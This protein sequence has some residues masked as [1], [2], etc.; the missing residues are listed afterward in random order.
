VE[1]PIQG[2]E[3]NREFLLYG[4]FWKMLRRDSRPRLSS[5][6]KLRRRLRGRWA[7]A[8]KTTDRLVPL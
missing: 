2:A 5:G 8:E 1:S 4:I 3:G 7:R 6:A